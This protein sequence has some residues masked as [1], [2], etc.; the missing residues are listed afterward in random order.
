[1]TMAFTLPLGI[2]LKKR[3]PSQ[4]IRKS[5][6]PFKEKALK[7]GAIMGAFYLAGVLLTTTTHFGECASDSLQGVR[8][9]LFVKTSTFERGSIVLIRGHLPQYDLIQNKREIAFVKRIIGMPGDSLSRDKERLC[10]ASLPQIH[11]PDS[12]FF[13]PRSRIQSLP[14]LDRTKDGKPLTPLNVDI[15]PPG[16]VFVAGDHVRS[17]DSR[18]EEFGLVPMAHLWGK[19]VLTW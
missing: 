2:S 12:P 9:G 16:Y 15:I 7:A 18:Y 6:K 1:M 10:V 4:D 8:Y 19:A 14:L 13:S 5:E 11:K 3:Q 17:F